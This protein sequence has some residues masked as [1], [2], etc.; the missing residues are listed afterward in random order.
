[1]TLKQ[2]I[3]LREYIRTGNM[4]AASLIAYNCSSTESAN[5]VGRNQLRSPIVKYHLGKIMDKAGLSDKYLVKSLKKIIEDGMKPE[6]EK[7]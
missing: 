5:Q 1:M 2:R 3:F 7:K 4:T 6:Q